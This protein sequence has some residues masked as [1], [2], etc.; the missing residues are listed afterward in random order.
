M[1]F[2]FALKQMIPLLFSYIFVG[3]AYGILLHEAG[4]SAIWTILSSLFIYAG[5][6]QI[7]M[8][9]FLT[10]GTPLFMVAIMTFFI[11]SRHLFYGIGFIDEFRKIGKQKNSFWKY[12][13]MALTVT[14][15]TFSILCSMECP[16]EVDKQKAEFY[17]L[18]LS[19][20]VWVGCSLLGTLCGNY[21]PF[22]MTGI[23][24]SATAFFVV[25]VVNQ[26]SKFPS[27]I[28]AV[29]GLIS[30]IIFLYLLGPDQ[31]ILPALSVSMI[32]LMLLKDGIYCKLE[33]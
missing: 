4:Y 10:S 30:S 27:K 20:L 13:Y 23:E 16:E 18:F 2:K 1:T 25:V 14:D 21:I 33:V 9:S 5:S 26:W 12:P 29:T 3:I 15:E 24:F 6:M 17:I 8:V 28:P 11:N 32:V 7:V 31:F 19:H 22:D